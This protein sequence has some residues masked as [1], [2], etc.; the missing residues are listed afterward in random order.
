MATLLIKKANQVLP[1]RHLSRAITLG[2]YINDPEKCVAK[3]SKNFLIPDMTEEEEALE[4]ASLCAMVDPSGKK[5]IE[6]HWIISW[7]QESGD[8]P[9]TQ[10]EIFKT[11]DET[12]SALGYGDCPYRVAIHGNTAH[13]HAHIDVL[14]IDLETNKLIPDSFDYLK[15]QRAVATITDKHGWKPEPGNWFKMRDGEVV[16]NPEKPK[17]RGGIRTRTIE[18]EKIT[19]QKSLERT[20][21]EFCDENR[22]YF[23]NWKWGDLHRGLALHGV[24][25]QYTEHAASGGGLAFSIDGKNWEKASSICPELSYP[26]IS[27]ALGAKGYRKARGEI[28]TILAEARK[29]REAQNGSIQQQQQGN[30]GSQAG[31]SRIENGTIQNSTAF[32]ERPGGMGRPAKGQA[33]E[34]SGVQPQSGNRTGG[35]ENNI[36]AGQMGDSRKVRSTGSL[37][38]RNSKGTNRIPERPHETAGS[39]PESAG[40]PHARGGA[41]AE[42]PATKYQRP[43][44]ST[45]KWTFTDE[46]RLDQSQK[47]DSGTGTDS[48]RL[49]EQTAYRSAFLTNQK[50]IRE[51]TD[52][53][54]KKFQS[55]QTFYSQR[56]LKKK[57][58]KEQRRQ[59]F[60]TLQN[61]LSSLQTFYDKKFIEKQYQVQ[62]QDRPNMN[63]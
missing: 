50:K 25:M 24:E 20:L 19:G 7:K 52:T 8:K 6:H 62:E 45:I 15:A 21:H 48:E 60:M 17:K 61:K 31:N 5:K 26:Q 13:P 53:L 42:Q 14:R 3:I 57:T 46:S 30:R 43:V 58:L 11:A 36:T 32:S 59:K 56:Y 23:P 9:L 37:D 55:L 40:S 38:Q 16:Y 49:R 27:K 39:N 44:G 28:K 18:T 51:K 35:H 34:F 22:K 1:S 4:I 29:N 47:A 10:D 54:R 63:M 2:H 33:T 41:R 12:M